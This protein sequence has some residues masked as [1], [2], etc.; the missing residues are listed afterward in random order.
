VL[1]IHSSIHNFQF[2]IPNFQSLRSTLKLAT[3]NLQLATFLAV[4]LATHAATAPS[5]NTDLPQTFP[6]P[7]AAV[8]ALSTAVTTQ[9]ADAL[10]DIFGP[11][12]DDVQNPDRVQATNEF[13]TFAEALNTTN[14]LV[15]DSDTNY[16]LEVGTNFWPFPIPLVNQQGHWFFDTSAGK[17]ELFNRR[18]GRNELN[19]LETIRAYVGAQRE[20]AGRDRNGD[21]VLQF[22]QRIF[23]SP[24]K[25]DGLYWPS[26]LD[27]EE[28]PLGPLIAEAQSAGYTPKS[29]EATE[30]PEPFHGYY[31][32]ILTCQGKHAPGE[33]YDY[34][35]NGR[36]I[37]GFALIAW[38]ATYDESGIMTFIVN[39]Q[40]RVYQKDLG[41][42]TDKLARKMTSYDPDPTWQVSPD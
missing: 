33:A 32:K 42:K 38:P 23:S 20:Y 16:V 2:L 9:N 35:I 10:H 7:Q 27:G 30:P 19:T 39:Q 34:V 18:I 8:A 41:P 6:T 11:N 5:T 37:A 40:G 13:N 21:E 26:D 28:S 12:A 29:G 17:E 14:R 4:A 3:F 1:A 25:K 31:F 15:K 24:G 22:A 36:M